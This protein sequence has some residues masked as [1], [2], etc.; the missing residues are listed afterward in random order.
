MFIPNLVAQNCERNPS[1]PFYIYAQPESEEIA[2]I[3]YLEFSRA[4]HRVANILRPNRQGRDG[5]VVAI[6]AHSDTVLYHAIVAGLMTADLI[7]RLPARLS[8]HVADVCINSHF[9]FLPGIRF[10][11]SSNC[12]VRRPAIALQPHVPRSNLC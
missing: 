2:T 3:T 11:E 4:T 12:C 9:R 10:R 7:V 5:E 8:A 1:R 6:I